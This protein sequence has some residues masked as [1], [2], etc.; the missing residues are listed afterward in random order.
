[1]RRTVCDQDYKITNGE[2]SLVWVS[3]IAMALSLFSFVTIMIYIYGMAD[4]LKKLQDLFNE[5]KEEE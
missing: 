1:M 4:H 2:D 5:R 3:L